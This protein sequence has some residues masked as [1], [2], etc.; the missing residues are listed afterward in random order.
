[1]KRLG[2]LP[3]VVRWLLVTIVIMSVVGI[4]VWAYMALVGTGTV[5]IEEC[6]SWVGP[7]EFE[8]SLY[9]QGSGTATLT[10]ANASPDS[11]Q[12]DLVSFITPVLTGITVDIPKKL[13]VPGNGQVDIDVVANASKSAEPNTYSILIEVNR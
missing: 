6:L 9:P 12:V 7:N 4:G 13:T 1:M 11:I 5:T 3:K 2:Y 10:L 8:V